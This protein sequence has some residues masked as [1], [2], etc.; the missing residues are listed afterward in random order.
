MAKGTEMVRILV[1]VEHTKYLW[2]ATLSQAQFY[3]LFS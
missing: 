2:S 1:V 3:M